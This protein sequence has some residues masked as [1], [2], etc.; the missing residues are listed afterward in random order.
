VR[1]SNAATLRERSLPRILLDVLDQRADG[2]LVLTEPGGREHAITFHD[3]EVASVE[4]DGPVAADRIAKTIIALMETLDASTSYVLAL[5]PAPRDGGGEHAPT[6]DPLPLVWA[7]IRAREL[8]DE[9]RETLASMGK[10]PIALHPHAPIDRFQLTPRELEDVDCI[11]QGCILE[12]RWEKLVALLVLTR[13]IDDGGWPIGISE[14]APPAPPAIAR[15]PIEPS[16]PI[17][18]P[19]PAEPIDEL[20]A[21]RTGWTRFRYLL[22]ATALVPLAFVIGDDAKADFQRRLVATL[23]EHPEIRDVVLKDDA[24]FNDLWAVL[25]EKKLVGAHLAS[26][27]HVHWIYG[28]LAA[29]AMLGV[30]LWLFERE[31]ARPKSLALTGLFT[32]T[33]GILLLLGFQYVAE[34]SQGLWLRGTSIVVVIFYIV[35]LIGFSYRAALDPDNGFF[36]SM[37]GFTCGVGFCEELVKALPVVWRYRKAHDH[38]WRDACVVG[39]ASG[40]G[41]GV[42]EGIMYAGDNYNG[43]STGGIY[44]VRFVSCVALHMIWAGAAALSI[45]HRHDLLANSQRWFQWLFNMARL[46]VVPMVLHGLYDTLL[47]RELDAYAL[48][49]AIVSFGFLAWQIERAR[50]ANRVWVLDT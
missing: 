15:R 9:T 39:L 16:R 50:K 32:G 24:T 40:V 27:S 4:S 21:A 33:I 17:E 5:T 19:R 3:G 2:R 31:R 1:V 7:G 20:P 48:A 26:D 28:A 45:H 47:K 18:A 37:F 42:A 38:G 10:R 23:D 30:V 22:L 34:Y 35:K 44:V 11:A 43:V 41:F 49:V 36:E 6:I 25:P 14:E 13:S 8:D 12:A 29:T 46:L